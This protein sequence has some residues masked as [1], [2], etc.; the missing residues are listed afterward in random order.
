MRTR[1][2]TANAAGKLLLLSI[3]AII[4]SSGIRA[5]SDTLPGAKVKDS[6][7]PIA[8]NGLSLEPLSQKF[9]GVVNKVPMNYVSSQPYISLQQLYIIR[10][11]I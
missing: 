6:I 10:K 5:Q 2:L 11:E 3:V 4:S 1:L 9:S 7:S 8:T